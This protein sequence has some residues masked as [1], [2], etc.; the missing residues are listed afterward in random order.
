VVIGAAGP[1]PLT[2]L[3][4]LEGGEEAG[5]L[6]RREHRGRKEVAAGPITLHLRDGEHLGRPPTPG[7]RTTGGT[8][9]SDKWLVKL[10]G[11]E[12][13]PITLPNELPRVAAEAF[14]P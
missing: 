2:A 5:R 4:L 9:L 1:A 11:Q 10:R 3:V 6:L 7:A 13:H 14:A 12:E 8:V